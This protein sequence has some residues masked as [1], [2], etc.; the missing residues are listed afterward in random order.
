MATQGGHASQWAASFLLDVMGGCGA[1]WGCSEAAD[2]RV[3]VNN[4][5]WRVWAS[6]VGGLC[7]YRWFMVELKTIEASRDT[8]CLS[9]LL[10]Q[11]FGGA[12]AVWGILEIL[13]IR[14][15][16]PPN[17]HDPSLGGVANAWAPG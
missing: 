12:G 15:N 5:Q 2:L 17:C 16:Y 6:I 13:G 11:V 8:E 1:V 14:V 9:S 7:L 10:L 3:G 4:D